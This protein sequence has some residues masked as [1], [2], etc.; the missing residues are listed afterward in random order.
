M[1]VTEQTKLQKFQGLF[2]PLIDSAA[3]NLDPDELD[4]LRQSVVLRMDRVADT[5]LG[6][7]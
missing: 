3:E 6:E 5:A 4:A 7:F 1:P 2:F